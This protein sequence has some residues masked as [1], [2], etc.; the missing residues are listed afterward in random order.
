MWWNRQT[1]QVESLV[2]RKAH[3]SSNLAYR[4]N[5]VVVVESAD[6]VGLNPTAGNRAERSSRSDD[7]NAAVA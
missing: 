4:T 2:G 7:T 6:T 5:F 1:P 3:A